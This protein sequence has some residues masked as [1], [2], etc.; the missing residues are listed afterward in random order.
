M[1]AAFVTIVGVRKSAGCHPPSVE[2]ASL[3]L[4]LRP[5]GDLRAGGEIRWELEVT[6]HSPH[7]TTL[8]FPTAQRGDV[9]LER[10]GT[11]YYR[12]SEGLL[13]AQV[14][15][16]QALGPGQ[17]HTFALEGRLQVE[18]GGYEAIGTLACRPAPAPGRTRVV[19][20]PPP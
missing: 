6:N 7:R 12:W 1:T 13:F 20:E 9:V 14:I 17:T 15:G 5:Q 10:H 18:P 3:T 16:E 11:V 2:A 19:V 8:I 4:S